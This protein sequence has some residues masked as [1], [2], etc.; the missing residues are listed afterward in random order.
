MNE[1]PP[2][3]KELA[4]LRD[5]A[6]PPRPPPGF[7]DRVAAKLAQSMLTIPQAPSPSGAATAGA[8]LPLAKLISG[9]VLVLLTGVGLGVA[10]DRNVLQPPPVVAP[11]PVI[12][13]P[14]VPVVVPVAP[15]VVPEPPPPPVEPVKVVVPPLPKPVTPVVEV[16]AKPASGRD[17]SL[18]VERALLEVARAAMAKGDLPAT[19][20]ALEKHQHDFANGR[21]AEER[22][23]LFIQ[24]LHAAGR[25]AEAA[26]RTERF[27]KQFP[28]S[29]LAP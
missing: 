10:L 16:P 27:N 29:L 6:R 5:A 17:V 14:V 2:L 1:L 25:E 20:T 23:A 26:T 4:A 11:P 18:S 21:L 24:A 7:E 19:F 28:D 22:E 8:Q 15:V 13:A 9:G 3:S 12:S